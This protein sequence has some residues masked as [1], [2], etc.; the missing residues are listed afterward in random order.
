M[1]TKYFN[2]GDNDWGIILIFDYSMLDWDD[3]WAIMRSF[4]M[5]SKEADNAIRILSS[6]NTG[7]TISNM[8]LRMSVVF[9]SK[10]TSTSEWWNTVQH[11]LTHVASAIIDYYGEDWFGEPAAYLSGHLLKRVIEDVAEPCNG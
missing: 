8:D 7:M 2:V 6:V 10:A 11:E 5:S 3:M 9:V 4:G 1:E